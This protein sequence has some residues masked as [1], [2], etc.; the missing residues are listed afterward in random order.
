ME[1]QLHGIH[2]ANKIEFTPDPYDFL[3]NSDVLYHLRKAKANLAAENEEK[4]PRDAKLLMAYAAA[5]I[6]YKN[7]QW[8]GVVQNLTVE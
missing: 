5:C 4:D 6:I 2:M 7:G 8:S 1:M 3:E